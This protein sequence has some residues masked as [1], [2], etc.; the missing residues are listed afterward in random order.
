ME[1]VKWGEIKLGKRK[2]YTLAYANDIVLLA[3]EEDEMRSM[4]SRLEEYMDRK[5][6]ELNA[7][8]TKIMRFRRKGGRMGRRE[9]R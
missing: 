9:W 7:N 5:G 4:I 3:K 1:R 2:I 8:K 6:L